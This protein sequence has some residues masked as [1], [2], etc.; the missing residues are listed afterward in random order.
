MYVLLYVEE[1][2]RLRATRTVTSY[3]QT[4]KQLAKPDHVAVS[5]PSQLPLLGSRLPQLLNLLLTSHTF[6]DSPASCPLINE[7]GDPSSSPSVE[8]SS[9]HVSIMAR[10]PATPAYLN[11]P[12][13]VGQA[14]SQPASK[15]TTPASS[16]L[17]TWNNQGGGATS[18]YLT[19]MPAR[20]VRIRAQMWF[21]LLHLPYFAFRR[22]AIV[23]TV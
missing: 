22:R 16:F 9:A 18:S 20:R 15:A 11:Q 1:R 8:P 6:Q 17:L 10:A 19:C 5:A 13:V 3:Y 7:A 12:K 2:E 23:A 14:Q 4:G 21:S